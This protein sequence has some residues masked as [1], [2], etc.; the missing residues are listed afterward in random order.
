MELIQDVMAY[1]SKYLRYYDIL[2]L[3][4][5]CREYLPS[6]LDL[7]YNNL[8]GQNLIKNVRYS[9][10]WRIALKYQ[11]PTHKRLVFLGDQENYLI[12]K[13]GTFTFWFNSDGVHYGIYANER[14]VDKFYRDVNMSLAG[15]LTPVISQIF[16]R[17]CLST[18]GNNIT[19]IEFYPNLQSVKNRIMEL[20]DDKLYHLYRVIDIRFTPIHFTNYSINDGDKIKIMRY[21]DSVLNK[22]KEEHL[23]DIE[24]FFSAE[25]VI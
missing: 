11:F 18:Y 6:S 24:R 22:T 10:F 4:L 21:H 8:S 25:M 13:T 2:A 1:A 3:T 19:Q 23:S 7:I 5:T 16:D 14:I 12:A 15:F 20:I 17:Y 9:Q